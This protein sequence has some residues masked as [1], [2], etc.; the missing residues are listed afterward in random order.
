[1]VRIF[2]AEKGVEVPVQQVDLRGGEHLTPAFRAINPYCTVPVLE[3]DD[4]TTLL[5]RQFRYPP[6]RSFLEVPAGKFDAPD[7]APEDVSERDPEARSR[8]PVEE[9]LWEG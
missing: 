8:R 6:R 1:M 3:L 2:M 5:V 9:L 7:E 4:G